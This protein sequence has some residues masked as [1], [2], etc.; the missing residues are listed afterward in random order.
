MDILYVLKEGLSPV[1]NKELIWSLRSLERCSGVGKVYIVGYCPAFLSNEIIKIPYKGEDID[2]N[3]Q[4]LKNMDIADRV[5]YAVKNSDIGE[6]FLVSMDDHFYINNTDFDN[7]PFYVNNCINGNLP[8]IGYLSEDKNSYFSFLYKCSEYLKKIGLSTLYFTSH[9]NNHASRKSIDACM[10]YIEDAKT[11]GECIELFVLL[12]NYR[13]TNGEIKPTIVND[14]K[15]RNNSRLRGVFRSDAFSTY[16][17]GYD[18]EL[19]RFLAE[20]YPNKSKYEMRVNDETENN[21]DNVV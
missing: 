18:S 17:F 11:S 19:Y 13:Y 4:R 3:D 9:R 16:D 10:K 12:N 6:E 7:Y 14:I 20:L 21:T 2:I 5:I 15:I 1:G 8:D